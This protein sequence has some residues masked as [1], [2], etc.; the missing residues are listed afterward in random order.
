[1]SSPPPPPRRS[2]Q[3]ESVAS[4]PLAVNLSVEKLNQLYPFGAADED[5]STPHG[6]SEAQWQERIQNHL[7]CGDSRAAIV[8]SISP[9]LVAAYTDEMDCV[10]M[11][12]FGDDVAQHYRLKIGDKLITSNTYDRQRTHSG[13]I[14]LGTHD[15]GRW[16]NFHPVI[17]EFISDDQD[18]MT[19]RRRAIPE[20]EWARTGKLAQLYMQEFAQYR[21]GR[22]MHSWKPAWFWYEED[23]GLKAALFDAIDQSTAASASVTPD[24][25]DYILHAMCDAGGG[26][27][28]LALQVK[29]SGF[30]DGH[31]YRFSIVQLDSLDD[32]PEITS[33]N[34]D[35]PFTIVSPIGL[36]WFMDNMT[37]TTIM[38]HLMVDPSPM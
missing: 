19:N 21:D 33:L 13:D 9:L 32:Y 36:L 16:Q 22:P 8:A 31:E 35:A 23:P 29:I 4:D 15:T 34:T 3:V 12:E 18:A 1:M 25:C 28:T 37:V 26:P 10:V 27:D 2:P 17:A 38:G 11:L 7:Y 24:A 20:T 6:L 5:G 14:L 30:L